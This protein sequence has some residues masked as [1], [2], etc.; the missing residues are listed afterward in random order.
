MFEKLTKE[1][2][3]SLPKEDRDN[4][5]IYYCNQQNEL[6]E[7]YEKDY[8]NKSEFVR[9]YINLKRIN[10]KIKQ[11]KSKMFPHNTDDFRQEFERLILYKS[12]VLFDLKRLEKI[13]LDYDTSIENLNHNTDLLK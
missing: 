7:Q 1:Y 2:I 3:E 12:R 11:L 10:K 8:K 9:Y 13:F 5:F 4:L 6:R